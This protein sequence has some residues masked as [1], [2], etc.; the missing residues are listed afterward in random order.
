MKLS[1]SEK[2]RTWVDELEAER[3]I[4]GKIELTEALH[5]GDEA[6]RDLRRQAIA[7][8]QAGK[9]EAC[10]DVVLGLAALGSVHPIDPLLL[11]RCYTAMGDVTNAEICT[12]HYHRLAKAFG[13]EA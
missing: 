12:E 5:L 3:F 2:I 9:L 8:Y 13:G 4:Q 6:A 1:G 10:I 11:A 7:L